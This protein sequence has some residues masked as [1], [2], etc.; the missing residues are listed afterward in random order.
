MSYPQLSSLAT[1]AGDGADTSQME[2]MFGM[3][4]DCMYQ[5][6]HGE[7]VFDAMDYTQKEKREFIWMKLHRK[8]LL[9]QKNF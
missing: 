4:Y 7:E 3:I 2:H 1:M 8:N 5:V 6:W 9:I